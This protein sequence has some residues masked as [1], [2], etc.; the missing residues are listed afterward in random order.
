LLPAR[1][2]D[3]KT[4]KTRPNKR[5]THQLIPGMTRNGYPSAG[6]PIGEKML[7][8][9]WLSAS[10]YA[11]PSLNTYIGLYHK[12]LISFRNITIDAFAGVDADDFSVK[13]DNLR[14][15]EENLR[16]LKNVL[17]T[18]LSLL[19]ADKRAVIELFYFKKLTGVQIVE[20]LGIPYNTYR[21]RKRAGL[22]GLSMYLYILG[23]TNERFLSYFDDEPLLVQICECLVEKN[24]ASPAKEDE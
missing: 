16:V 15:K 21:Y 24:L 8:K 12:R 20:K 17:E 4:S 3:K 7:D 2:Y 19:D 1:G 10:L 5:L 23:M 11:Y 18:A 6:C 9:L 22:S 13:L 14:K